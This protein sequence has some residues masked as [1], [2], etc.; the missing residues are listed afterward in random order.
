MVINHEDVPHF[1]AAMTM[2]FRVKDA[3]MLTNSAVG[4]QITFQLHVTESDSWVDHI[5]R[6]AVTLLERPPIL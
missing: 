6:L 3:A 4:D 2:P 5:E 1:M